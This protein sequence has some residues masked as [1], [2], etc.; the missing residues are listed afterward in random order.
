[1]V[2]I[3]KTIPI[4]LSPVN[5]FPKPEQLSKGRC[6][7]S[8]KSIATGLTDA[9]PVAAYMDSL[10]KNLAIDT[11]EAT[12]HWSRNP[13]KPTVPVE[14][15]SYSFTL[16]AFPKPTNE[17]PTITIADETSI[18]GRGQATAVSAITE[19]FVSSAVKTS[20]SAL[21]EL[22]K[23]ESAKFIDRLNHL[24]DRLQGITDTINSLSEK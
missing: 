20:I 7:Q 5:P 15:V 13:W 19:G 21:E 22:R 16:T 23:T 8:G 18:A 11:S 3:W 10:E 17:N 1:M 14:D 6:A 9:S 2:E 4:E 24:E 12:T